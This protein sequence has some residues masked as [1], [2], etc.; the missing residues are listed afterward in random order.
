MKKQTTPNEPEEF[1]LNP[2]KRELE[3]PTDPTPLGT[4]Q[5]A[6]QYEPQEL[7]PSKPEEHP[8]QQPDKAAS[9]SA[10]LKNRMG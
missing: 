9:V 1:P 6:P 3:R 4:P 7:P 2:G 10:E 5:E 8:I